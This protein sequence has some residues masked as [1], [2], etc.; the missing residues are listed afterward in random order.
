MPLWRLEPHD[1]SNRHWN[2][3]TYKGPVVIRAGDADA[4]QLLAARA[5]GKATGKDF[6]DTVIVVPWDQRDLISTTQVQGTDEY[7]EEG[8]SGIVHPLEAL[9]LAHRGYDL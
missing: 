1:L 8:P 6:G 9:E 7:V 4:A 5:F 2:A 3:S